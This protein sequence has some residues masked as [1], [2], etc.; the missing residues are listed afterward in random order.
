MDPTIYDAPSTEPEG[1]FEPR[2]PR[3]ETPAERITFHICVAIVLAVGVS[4]LFTFLT[5]LAMH[6]GRL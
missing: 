1:A 2:T 3:L 5:T 6:A 4:G